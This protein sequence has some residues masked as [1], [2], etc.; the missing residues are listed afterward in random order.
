MHTQ[1]AHIFTHTSVKCSACFTHTHPHT[2]A[3]SLNLSIPSLPPSLPPSSSVVPP[4]T[5]LQWQQPFLQLVLACMNAQA[6]THE[7]L[8]GPLKSQLQSFLAAFDKV[9]CRCALESVAVGLHVDVCMYVHTIDT[10]IIICISTI[11]TLYL[12]GELD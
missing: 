6:T 1:H 3:L 4:K 2:L 5:G 12:P 10:C 7:E 11:F 8:L 9:G